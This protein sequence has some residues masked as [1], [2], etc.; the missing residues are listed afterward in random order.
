MDKVKSHTKSAAIPKNG[1]K[2]SDSHRNVRQKNVRRIIIF[3]LV[4]VTIFVAFF[5]NFCY[6]LR[7]VTGDRKAIVGYYAENDNSIDMVYIG[8]STVYR[9][10]SPMHAWEKSGLTSYS[11]AGTGMPATM[12]KPMLDEAFKTQSPK[13]VIIDLYSYVARNNNKAY[14]PVHIERISSSL[15]YS[16]NR[17]EIIDNTARYELPDLT[18]EQIKNF[19][20]D[21]RM[22]Y[23]RLF[24]LDTKS[25]GYATNHVP[26]D[27]KGFR[28]F[29]SRQALEAPDFNVSNTKGR[30]E[31]SDSTKTML[32]DVMDYSKKNDVKILFVMSPLW[33]TET[34]KR[35]LNSIEDYVTQRGFEFIDMCE[36]YAEIGIDFRTDY[37]NEDHVNILGA[38]KYTAYLVDYLK[39][40]YDFSDH[41]GE[42]TYHEWNDSYDKYSSKVEETK[43]K[44][45][46]LE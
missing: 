4:F 43:F 11:F 38:E 1:S 30:A 14:Y 3:I 39:A 2:K 29:A 10:W 26:D 7:P 18:E 34:H 6:L 41:R 33:I 23:E 12:N 45:K 19:K 17:N 42:D 21:I 16:K 15:N 36:R 44:L 32:D 20:Q 25:F 46:D 40:N 37:Y 24:D 13:L 5:D 22:Y 35:I 9:Y 28:F 31:I 27:Y 8:A